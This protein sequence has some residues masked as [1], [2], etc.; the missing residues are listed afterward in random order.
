MQTF[1]ITT[2]FPDH[3]QEMWFIA[4]GAR[5]T[6]LIWKISQK[7]IKL[8]AQRSVSDARR[9]EGKD[10]C[11]VYRWGRDGKSVLLGKQLL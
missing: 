8:K 2:F 7:A 5:E 10:R 6:S 9:E 4:N 3:Y 11:E 1:Q